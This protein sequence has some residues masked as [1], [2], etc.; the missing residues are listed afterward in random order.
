MGDAGEIP[1]STTG[2]SPV[3]ETYFGYRIYKNNDGYKRIVINSKEGTYNY[4][5]HRLEW[6]FHHGEIPK[7]F[8]IHHKDHNRG[9]NDIDNL[10]CV[11]P[12]QHRRLHPEFTPRDRR[13][14]KLL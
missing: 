8:E 10:E 14:L 2:Q 12:K 3:I 6:E 4:A 5:I 11:T 7:G 13:Q 1:A 9:N